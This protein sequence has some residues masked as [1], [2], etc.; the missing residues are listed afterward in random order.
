MVSTISLSGDGSPVQ[1]VLIVIVSPILKL[2]PP[3]T[4]AGTVANV[5]TKS[6]PTPPP[7]FMLG[8][9]TVSALK[10]PVPAEVILTS[11]TVAEPAAPV[12]VT[13]TIKP[14]PAP[15]VAL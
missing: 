3:V 10:Y 11:V 8:K 4:R 6:P 15:L 9:V 2:L 12:V 5:I 14:I 1:G 13:L 7:K